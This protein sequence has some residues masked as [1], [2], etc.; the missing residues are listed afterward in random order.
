LSRKEKKFGADGKKK[1]G[2]QIDPASDHIDLRAVADADSRGLMQRMAKL[3]TDFN[4][5]PHN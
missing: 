3:E 4:K 1:Q 5:I 2:Y